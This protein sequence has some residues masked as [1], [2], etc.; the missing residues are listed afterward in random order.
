M[1]ANANLVACLI[2]KTKSY[3]GSMTKMMTP[4]LLSPTMRTRMVMCHPREMTD[5]TNFSA[6]DFYKNDYPDED[7]ENLYS[8]EDGDFQGTGNLRLQEVHEG[9]EYLEYHGEPDDDEGQEDSYDEADY[10]NMFKHGGISSR[11]DNYTEDDGYS[12]D[13]EDMESY[14]DRIFGDLQKEIDERKK[15][16]QTD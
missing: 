4:T 1:H 8:S 6:E 11:Y 3:L 12:G 2:P 16:M 13:S 7:D 9:R 10:E 14:R 5:G 15:R